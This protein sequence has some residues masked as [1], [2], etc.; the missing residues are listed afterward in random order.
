MN[1]ISTKL[2]RDNGP[3]QIGENGH[4]EKSWSYDINEQICQFFFQLVRAKDTK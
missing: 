3:I 2:D 1:I 4:V